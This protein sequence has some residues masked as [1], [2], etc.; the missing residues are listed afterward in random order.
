MQQNT[1]LHVLIATI[2]RPSL[3]NMLRTIVLQPHDHLTIVFD[4]VPV[5]VSDFVRHHLQTTR[6]YNVHVFNE[7]VRLGAWGHGIRNKYQGTLQGDFV[8]HADDDDEYTP[9]AFEA[10]RTVCS[11]PEAK[12][13]INVFSLTNSC[14]PRRCLQKRTP[15]PS[16]AIPIAHSSKGQWISERGG[17]YLYY[18]QLRKQVPFVY[19][20]FV[21]Y[22][23]R[24]NP[25]QKRSKFGASDIID[26]L[27]S[28]PIKQSVTKARNK[29]SK[30]SKRP[31]MRA[32]RIAAKRAKA[33]E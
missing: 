19:H 4:K 1:V 30:R 33:N 14:K 13:Q 27:S 16:G 24:P 10:I 26:M 21:I 20:P 23:I 18:D 31:T 29:R 12:D 9:G 25:H 15:T 32:I 5:E 7:P 11:A 28:S 22:R 3:V 8:L 2:G 6:D 17:D